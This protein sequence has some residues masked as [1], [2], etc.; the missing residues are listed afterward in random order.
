MIKV[1]VDSVT[2]KRPLPEA[3]ISITVK[4]I[5]KGFE[6]L[7]T[8]R[9]DEPSAIPQIPGIVALVDKLV[10]MGF[11]PSR[12]IYQA[13]LPSPEGKETGQEKPVPICAVHNTAMVWREG[14][15]K[16]TGKH[17]AF[18]ACPER[19]DDGSFCKYHSDK[20]R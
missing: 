16:Q 17:Y 19:N 20:S 9:S 7:I 3:P 15:N 6:I 1:V 18:W 2:E 11:E 5:Y 4:A 8:R 12:V 10:E 13:S 14:N